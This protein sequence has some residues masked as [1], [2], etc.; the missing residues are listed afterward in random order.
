MSGLFG[1]GGGFVMIPLLSLLLGMD[2]HR[3]QGATLAIMMMP[4]GVPGVLQYRKKGVGWDFRVVCLVVA[5]FVCG[6][7][8]GAAAGVAVP[9]MPLRLGFMALLLCVAA[10]AWLRRE[11]DGADGAMGGGAGR[12][13]YG[14]IGPVGSI[15]SIALPGLLAGAAGGVTSGLTG[16]GG[17]V[18]IIP[19]LVRWFR[20]TQH[21]AQMTS[22]MVLLPPIGLPGVLVYAK[23]AGGLPWAV[24][25]GAAAGFDLGSYLGARAAVGM[26]GHR[27]K[28]LYS[29]ALLCMAGA[30]AW[31]LAA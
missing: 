17:A 21:Q 25:L 28:R 27:L 14:S 11:A 6:V 12:G 18:V 20:M 8:L 13:A 16:L 26:A 22:L 1:V 30:M 9:Q 24:I 2:Q 29:L 15:G 10:H 23:A 19:L 7:P 3:A 4:I 5:G 31:R